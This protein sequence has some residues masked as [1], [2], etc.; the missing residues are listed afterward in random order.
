MGIPANIFL[1]I[2]M[3]I[4]YNHHLKKSKRDGLYGKTGEKYSC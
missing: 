3:F 1:I 4:I 2:G